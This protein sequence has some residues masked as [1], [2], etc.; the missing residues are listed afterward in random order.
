MRISAHWPILM[1]TAS[2]RPSADSP[3]KIYAKLFQF[4]SNSCQ[5]GKFSVNLQHK[6]RKTI[7][8]HENALRIS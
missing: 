1:A 2:T 5:I 4:Y 8:D 3:E 6:T 7:H